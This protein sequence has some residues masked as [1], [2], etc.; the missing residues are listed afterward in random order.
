MATS[1]IN[2]LNFMAWDKNW[3]DIYNSLYVCLHSGMTYYVGC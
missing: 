1:A 2:L 3:S